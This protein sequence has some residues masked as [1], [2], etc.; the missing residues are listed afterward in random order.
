[1]FLA[2]LEQ[3]SMAE[4]PTT[5]MPWKNLSGFRKPAPS[6]QSLKK[7]N[8]E[9]DCK[10]IRLNISQSSIQRDMSGSQYYVMFPVIV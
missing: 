8:C 6:A 1:M 10:Q 9:V 3:N 7:G 5:E 2:F 4:I